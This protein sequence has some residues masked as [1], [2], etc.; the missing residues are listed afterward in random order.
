MK[1]IPVELN[2]LINLYQNG[3]ITKEGLTAI[4][5]IQWLAG[6]H[7]D[8]LSDSQNV[9]AAIQAMTPQKT[10]KDC[11]QFSS[12]HHCCMA[13]IDS[14]STY[15]AV[16]GTSQSCIDFEGVELPSFLGRRGML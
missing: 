9:T 4:A 12:T 7:P 6:H 1:I 15:L 11:I 8:L 14:D 5:P 3:H 16:E 2:N 10:C 13:R